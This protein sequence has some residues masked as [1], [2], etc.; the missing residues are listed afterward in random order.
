MGRTIA[1]GLA[2]VC[3]FSLSVLTFAA[4]GISSTQATDGDSFRLSSRGAQLTTSTPSVC[5]A[6]TPGPGDPTAT[7]PASPGPT[8]FDTIHYLTFANDSG[9]SASDFH[10]CFNRQLGGGGVDMN[11]P[12]CPSPAVTSVV[13]STE[14]HVVWPSACVDPGEAVRLIVGAGGTPVVVCSF[15]TLSGTQISS[16][17]GGTAGPTVSAPPPTEPPLPVGM[18]AMSIDMDE[19]AAP[20]N[21]STALGS[22]ENCARI[23]ENNV[24]DADEDV[25]DGVQIDV[26]AA[27]IPPYSNGG[28]P[29]DPA[30]DT[31]GITAYSYVINYPPSIT[32]QSIV[33]TDPS[34][35]V[36]PRGGSIVDLSGH[37]PGPGQFQAIA[38]DTGVGPFRS[39]SGVLDRITFVSASSAP[40]SVQ[41]LSL[42]E[43]AHL[44]ASGAA[45]APAVVNNAL[46]AVNIECDP[47]AVTPG[48][49]SPAPPSPTPGPPTPT[50]TPSPIP[51]PT[52]SPR[53]EFPM[54]AMSIDMDEAATPA[55]TSSSIGSIETCRRIDENGTLDADED[56]VDALLID[57]TA[58][59]V[60]PYDDNGTPGD[61][62][63]DLGGIIAY[64]YFFSYFPGALNVEGHLFDSPGVNLLAR[65]AGSEM[66]DVSDPMPDSDGSF[67]GTVLDTSA[68]VPEA[69]D[70]VLSRLTLASASSAPAGNYALTLTENAHLEVQGYA[71]TPL[72]TNNAIVAVNEACG[73]SEPVTPPPTPAPP[74]ITPSP[75]P[76][77]TPTPASCPVLTPTPT[78]TALVGT[79]APATSLKHFCNTNNQSASGL[80]I[81]ISNNSPSA[82]LHQN[83]Q[84]CPQPTIYVQSGS[85]IVDVVWPDACVDQGEFVSLVLGCDPPNACG[86]PQVLCFD[87]TRFGSLLPSSPS[88]CATTPSP[89]FGPTTAAPTP[90]RTASPSPGTPTPFP[91]TPNPADCRS[92]TPT[93]TVSPTPDPTP[94]WQP[95]RSVL[96]CQTEGQA[97][98]DLHVNFATSGTS[99]L[100]AL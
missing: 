26:T 4:L 30:D 94:P 76:S 49:T 61:P 25:V 63:D 24:L 45:F 16:C 31:G 9:Q 57:V 39:G 55:N 7:P 92:W 65:T 50:P 47:L 11:A 66:F 99:R 38:L 2:V 83:A 95:F 53:P 19:E 23:N 51:T 33:S 60:A 75:T 37:G 70:G 48:P 77:P 14:I 82:Q 84:G 87:W 68:S 3:F 43:P 10:V 58:Q 44:D 79:P 88:P 34:V 36:L 89:T 56:S 29:G 97:V 72:I 18:D 78:P 90:P 1:V 32:F 54:D 100:S 59:G 52:P 73:A 41:T 62:T 35:N 21:S 28:T 20:A 69:G 5:P 71:Y 80:H 12:G 13:R 22:R 64:S 93:P 46:V 86:Q 27:G 6:P 67:L 40:S 98:S 85:N 96:L 91:G 81:R 42:T 15:W 74:T 17:P 8:E